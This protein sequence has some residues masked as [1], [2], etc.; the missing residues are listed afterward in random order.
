MLNKVKQL[1]SI[2]GKVIIKGEHPIF[3]GARCD[4]FE[5]AGRGQTHPDHVRPPAPFHGP[6]NNCSS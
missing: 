6:A 3:Y 4:R 2:T 5:E 1:L